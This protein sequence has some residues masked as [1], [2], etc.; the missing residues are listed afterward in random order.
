MTDPIEHLISL[1]AQ[2]ETRRSKEHSEGAKCFR[3]GQ[4]DGLTQAIDYLCEAAGGGPEGREKEG[5]DLP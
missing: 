1:R 3:D 4:I 2:I 5:L